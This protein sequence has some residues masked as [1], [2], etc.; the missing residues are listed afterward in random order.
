MYDGVLVITINWY[1]S[2][3]Q[4]IG[5]FLVRTGTAVLLNI[6]PTSAS[7]RTSNPKIKQK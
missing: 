2:K 6:V 4:S 3:V 1:Y 7:M 5:T